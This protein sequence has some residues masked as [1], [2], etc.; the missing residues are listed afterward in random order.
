MEIQIIF[1]NSMMEQDIV[2]SIK[3]F[4]ITLTENDIPSCMLNVNMYFLLT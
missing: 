3:Q 2:F 1:K 4:K